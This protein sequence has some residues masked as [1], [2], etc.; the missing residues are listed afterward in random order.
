MI[1][2]SALV[3]LSFLLAGQP[4]EWSTHR[5]SAARTGSLDGQSGPAKPKVLWTHASRE[6]YVAGLVTSG[7]RLYAAALGAFNSGAFHSIDLADGAA[8]RIAWTK[9]SPLLRVPA[10][11]SAAVSEGKVVLGEGMHQT[12]GGGLLCFRAS[13][14]R[15]LWRLSIAGELVHL[16]GS[17][18]IAG[19]RVYTGGG[20]AGVV[21]V[22]LGRVTLEGKEL[23]LAE[24]EAAQDKIWKG[25]VAKYE[26]EKKKDPDFAIPPN[27]M[28]LT[29]PAPKMWWQQGK[30]AWHVDGPTTVVDGK[31]LA[32]SAYLDKEKKGERALFCMDAA[33]GKILWKAALMFNPW[34]GASVAGGRAIVSTSSIRYDPQAVSGARGEIVSLK[35]ADGS[36][37]WKREV[38]AGV[39]GSVA[40]SGDLAIFTD[41]GGRIQA[42]DVKTGQPRW[43]FRAEAPFFAGPA[44]SKDAVYGVSLPGVAYAVGLA[45]GKALW[46]LDVAQAAGAPGMV[47]GSPAL[48]QGR[49]YVGTGNIEGEMAGKPTF[50]AC[51]GEDK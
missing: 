21:C 43:S 27:E 6:H 12:D 47:Y 15:T 39:L 36:V 3:V 13:D 33:D 16:E 17:P 24:A 35:L 10:V 30:G 40:I 44:V 34:G 18:T 2:A 46:R 26:E 49:L 42:L 4:A 37:E 23:A 22:D 32:G 45:D 1:R 20:S 28:T 19:G 7:D 8:K 11:C 9:A 38:D 48:H 50:L 5:G 25:L 51:I 41:T 31:V 14:G 29:Q